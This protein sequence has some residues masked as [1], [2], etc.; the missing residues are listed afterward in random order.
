M[1]LCS[2]HTDMCLRHEDASKLS[3]L[4]VKRGTMLPC[5]GRNMVR[6]LTLCGASSAWALTP[7]MKEEPP[8][9]DL[10]SFERL[11]S[12]YVGQ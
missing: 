11:T 12:S 9:S 5:D 10:T 1:P 3:R 7:F 2:G 6:W 4:V 8:W